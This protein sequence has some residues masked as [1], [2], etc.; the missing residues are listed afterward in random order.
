M[1]GLCGCWRVGSGSG[2]NCDGCGYKILLRGALSSSSRP[3]SLTDKVA[4]NNSQSL[5]AKP[6]L[7]PATKHKKEKREESGKREALDVSNGGGAAAN[8]TK[9]LPLTSHHRRHSHPVRSPPEPPNAPHLPRS[10]QR[11]RLPQSSAYNV[12]L[13]PSSQHTLVSLI[14]SWEGGMENMG[15]GHNVHQPLLLS[16]IQPPPEL[17]PPTTLPP[18]PI[19]RTP[20]F[21]L[22]TFLPPVAHTNKLLSPPPSPRPAMPCLFSGVSA[23]TSL[24]VRY[25]AL[26]LARAAFA[27]R[28]HTDLRQD[29]DFSEANK[30]IN[31]S[32][33][34]EKRRSDILTVGEFKSKDYRSTDAQSQH[35]DI[36]ETNIQTSNGSYA[37]RTLPAPPPPQQPRRYVVRPPQ[38]DVDGRGYNVPSYNPSVSCLISPRRKDSRQS[39]H[40][41]TSETEL[42]H[43][44]RRQLITSEHNA[45]VQSNSNHRDMVLKHFQQHHSR[46]NQQ[47]QPLSDPSQYQK[48]SHYQ[49]RSDSLLHHEQLQQQQSQAQSEHR[50]HSSKSHHHHR[51]HHRH[52]HHSSRRKQDN[53][54]DG[55]GQE[56]KNATDDP[57]RNEFGSTHQNRGAENKLFYENE[58]RDSRLQTHRSSSLERKRK[59]TDTSSFQPPDLRS[60]VPATE[61]A[62]SKDAL[63][64]ATK[65]PG[66]L[67]DHSIPSSL[68]MA[69]QCR[70]QSEQQLW[71]EGKAEESIELADQQPKSL[72]FSDLQVC[73]KWL[74]T[75]EFIGKKVPL[76]NLLF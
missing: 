19:T 43:D 46:E 58:S 68:K 23:S 75:P 33:R 34:Q 49:Q 6:P 57:Q 2:G 5:A 55:K 56:N 27:T 9:K 53:R 29:C 37:S 35:L 25:K 61:Y 16:T 32:Q 3:T 28:S 64:A 39:F 76:K 38:D 14:P 31:G 42:H 30:V 59:H 50:R 22:S 65:F 63:E 11:R 4:N 18:S 67:K 60:G 73:L 7:P 48:Y 15:Y 41:T 21:D 71:T 44:Y 72:E 17:C 10:L 66:S 1:A 74:G 24:Q 70:A 12:P 54:S 62:S 52:R 45:R 47:Q 36:R 51:R 8:A 40:V 26:S 20:P 13:P 69:L